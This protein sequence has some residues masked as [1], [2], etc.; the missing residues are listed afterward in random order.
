MSPLKSNFRVITST[1]LEGQ[2]S[3]KFSKKFFWSQLV[4]L[5]LTVTKRYYIDTFCRSE[6]VE[7][8]G[9]KFGVIANQFL[10]F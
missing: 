9:P 3:K 10:C 1:P 7:N 6:H 4:D 8:R 2:K 5:V